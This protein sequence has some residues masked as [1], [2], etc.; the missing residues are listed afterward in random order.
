[1]GNVLEWMAAI[2]MY[3]YVELF[4]VHSISG[5]ALVALDDRQLMVSGITQHH[6]R[7]GTQAA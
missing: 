4:R 7:I 1:M 6:P 2:N 3:R 5:N